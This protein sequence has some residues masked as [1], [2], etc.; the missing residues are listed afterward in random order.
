MGSY[1]TC[2]T[3]SAQRDDRLSSETA[4]R[5]TVFLNLW[6]DCE[7]RWN[8]PIELT[9]PKAA[10]PQTHK[11]CPHTCF[12]SMCEGCDCIAANFFVLMEFFFHTHKAWFERVI[13]SSNFSQAGIPLSSVFEPVKLPFSSTLWYCHMSCFLLT[14]V[15][16]AGNKATVDHLAHYTVA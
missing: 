9:M 7:G 16:A 11:R 12:S 4:H 3:V 13:I 15:W 2:A 14:P 1:F 10:D 8:G 5:L 6:D